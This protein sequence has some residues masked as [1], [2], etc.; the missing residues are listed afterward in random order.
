MKTLCLYY[1][2]TDKTKVVMETIAENICADIAE[3]TDGKDRKGVLGYIGACFVN[4]KNSLARVHITGDTDL[5]AYDRVI[6][7]MPVWVE[8]PC[9]IGRALIKKY[10][11]E[12]PSEVYFVCT[13][14]GANDYMSKIKAMDGL[15]GRASSGQFSIRTKENDYI[16]ESRIIADTL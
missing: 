15:L 10:C 8:G 16:T 4:V 13:H 6:I 11:S 12:M 14:M 5:K 9:A 1:S 2:R 3:Y 7:G